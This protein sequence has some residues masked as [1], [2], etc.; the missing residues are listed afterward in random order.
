MHNAAV[1]ANLL[2][3]LGLTFLQVILVNYSHS[4]PEKSCIMKKIESTGMAARYPFNHSS[5]YGFTI[6]FEYHV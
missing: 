4:F 1:Y 6:I 3:S 2:E 5:C